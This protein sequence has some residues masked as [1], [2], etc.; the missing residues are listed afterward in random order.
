MYNSNA[1]WRTHLFQLSGH[2]ISYIRVGLIFQ[3]DNEPELLALSEL[4]LPHNHCQWRGEPPSGP[5]TCEKK[6]EDEM[7]GNSPG[8]VA[9]V[10]IIFLDH[11]KLVFMHETTMAIHTGIYYQ[12][13]SLL[14]HHHS[15]LTCIKKNMHVTCTCT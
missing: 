12:L 6:A 3:S 5:R 11:W 7:K 14:V 4:T 2:S 9:N 13:V 10:S 8:Q 15:N 1:N